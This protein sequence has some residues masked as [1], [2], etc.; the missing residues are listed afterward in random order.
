MF[1]VVRHLILF[2]HFTDA[3]FFGLRRSGLAHKVYESTRTA[4]RLSLTRF[5]TDNELS[6]I[7]VA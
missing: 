5:T 1:L 7:D 2:I 6:F 4:I 3:F